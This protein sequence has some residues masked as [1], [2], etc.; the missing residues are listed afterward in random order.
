VPV[1]D[2][3]PHA[4]ADDGSSEDAGAYAKADAKDAFWSSSGSDAVPVQDSGPHAEADD[5]SAK[6]SGTDDPCS[7]YPSDTSAYHRQANGDAGSVDG[8]ANSD[9][10]P[11]ADDKEARQPDPAAA[12]AAAAGFAPH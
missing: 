10:D 9:A 5:G 6:D 11:H 7:T 1:Q 4:E 3:G 8:Q 12:A 2:S